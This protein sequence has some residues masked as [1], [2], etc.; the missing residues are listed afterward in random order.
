MLDHAPAWSG[1]AAYVEVKP[2]LVIEGIIPD[3]GGRAGSD[4]N[5]LASE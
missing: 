1:V 5:R 2:S 3:K 4:L